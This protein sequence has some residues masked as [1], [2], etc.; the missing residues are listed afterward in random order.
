MRLS[1][2]LVLVAPLL[3]QE[4]NPDWVRNHQ[5]KVEE[6]RGLAFKADV[7]V[8][9]RSR[10][11]LKARMLEKF[12]EDLPP[13]DLAKLEATLRAFG[14]VE[15]GVD[16]KALIVRFFTNEVAA[17]YDPRSGE[18]WMIEDESSAGDDEIVIIH[19]M[20]HA[21]EDQHFDLEEIDRKFKGHDDK[22]NAI[23]ALTEGS[24]TLGMFLPE[25]GGKVSD[26]GPADYEM[27]AKMIAGLLGLSAKIGQTEDY[28]NIFSEGWIFPYLDG[29]RFVAAI[30]KERG[31]EGVNEAY[32]NP[33]AS[34]EQVLH[35]E[36]YL[37]PEAPIEVVLPETDGILGKSW[38][39][40]EEN[41]MG[42]FFTRLFLKEHL[43][44]Q[45]ARRLLGERLGASG[46]VKW[47]GEGAVGMFV[48]D[49]ETA[50]A[51][52][53]GDRYRIYR[54]TRTGAYALL[55]ATVW[56]SDAEARQFLSAYQKATRRRWRGWDE[57]RDRE[58]GSRWTRGILAN[59]ARRVGKDVYIVEGVP[60]TRAKKILDALE[61]G[62]RY[63]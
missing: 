10:E 61:D 44:V 62:V 51:G 60:A 55:W 19:E 40:V 16:L 22:A 29:L 33:P 4:T 47:L 20:I 18:L 63:R 58:D 26:D 57:E 14:F 36:K 43:V 46:I 27:Q 35:P 42:E 9:V 37:V 56:D 23:S 30:Y 41:T 21:L 59:A 48:A 5:K 15:S 24:A 6:I 11:D 45:P 32:A 49:P 31:W 2:L 52:W 50:A 7:G 54:S 12:D 34:T 28:P 39:R 3:A 17:F 53:G 8:Q 38:E 1:L 13:A 25:W